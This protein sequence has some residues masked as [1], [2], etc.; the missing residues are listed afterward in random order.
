LISVD[1]FILF[2]YQFF[3]FRL[4]SGQFPGARR[5]RCACSACCCWIMQM[6]TWLIDIHQRPNKKF[7]GTEADCMYVIERRM[8]ARRQQSQ[9]KSLRDNNVPN[10]DCHMTDY[11]Y[12]DSAPHLRLHILS[13]ILGLRL[14]LGVRVRVGSS[15]A[16]GVLT[17][18]YRCS[19]TADDGR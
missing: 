10:S 9:S 19:W 16:M 8:R 7:K 13:L 1:I 6:C 18:T 3:L 12:F 2:H 5:T 4:C 17:L 11:D 14:S 15:Y